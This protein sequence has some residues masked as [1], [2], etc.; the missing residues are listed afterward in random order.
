MWL[1]TGSPNKNDVWHE[2]MYQFLQV[3]SFP[4]THAGHIGEQEKHTLF[5]P[6][7]LTPPIALA[8]LEPIQPQIFHRTQDRRRV[9][10]GLRSWYTS[11]C[12]W[13]RYLPSPLR[14]NYMYIYVCI[15][16][17]LVQA[18]FHQFQWSFPCFA[19]FFPV[20]VSHFEHVSNT[21]SPR[22]NHHQDY[23]ILRRESR[24]Y[25]NLFVTVAGW[26][27]DPT[28]NTIGPLGVCWHAIWGLWD[29]GPIT[30]FVCSC[31]I[32]NFAVE[33]SCFHDSGGCG[34]RAAR[35]FGN[36]EDRGTSSVCCFFLGGWQGML[37][38]SSMFIWFY[39]YPGI[40]YLT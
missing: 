7:A 35:T 8:P 32:C 24:L 21:L 22:N 5:Q 19:S 15:A 29:F 34:I 39:R 4:H 6:F 14:Y 25:I 28:Y 10:A 18:V 33:I 3:A 12:W 16:Y 20:H 30:I 17:Q 11:Y 13:F 37:E 38:H 36:N 2:D 9:C 31:E 1:A 26:G 23:Y 27:I 40:P